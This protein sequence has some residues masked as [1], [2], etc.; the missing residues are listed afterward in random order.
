MIESERARLEREFDELMS[1]ALPLL[2]HRYIIGGLEHLGSSLLDMSREDLKRN[3]REEIL[4][5][6]IYDAAQMRLDLA[7]TVVQGVK[8]KVRAMKPLAKDMVKQPK[9]ISVRYEP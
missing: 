8:N 4:D 2:K 3:K 6:F 5:A 9:K 1:I 7:D